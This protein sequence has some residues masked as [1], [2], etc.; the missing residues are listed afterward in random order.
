MVDGWVFGVPEAFRDQ[1]DIV[2]SNLVDADKSH[3]LRRKQPRN[4][5]DLPLPTVYRM[6]WT[7]GKPP[8]FSFDVG[9]IFYDPISARKMVWADALKVLRRTVQVTEARSDELPKSGWVKVKISYFDNG[10]I[11]STDN[12]NM[13]QSEL[14]AFLRTGQLPIPYQLDMDLVSAM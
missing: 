10:K 13:S 4:E 8:L 12:Y 7:Q 3:D 11:I 6:A 2:Y 1:L 14:V 9:H 5:D